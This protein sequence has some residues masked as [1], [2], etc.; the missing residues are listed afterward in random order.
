MKIIFLDFDGVITVP[1]TRWHLSLT[2]MKRLRE[3]LDATDA[4]IVVSSSWRRGGFE[5][6]MEDIQNPDY[7]LCKPL[8]HNKDIGTFLYPEKIIDITP[9]IYPQPLH[10]EPGVD[11]GYEIDA[12]LKEHPEVSA[13]IILDDEEDFLESQKPFHIK[14][15][16]TEGLTQDQVQEAI[17]L[18]TDGERQNK[19]IT[20]LKRKRRRVRI[21]RN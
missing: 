4:K 15:K 9:T 6:F 16:Y 13:Y 14:T 21:K 7:F 3:I 20:E 10:R 17:N 19:R 8:P 18:L 1:S 2:H 5:N 12:W 11:R